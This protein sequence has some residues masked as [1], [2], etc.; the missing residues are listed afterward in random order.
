[1]VD[2]ARFLEIAKD[3]KERTADD[4]R[5]LLEMPARANLNSFLQGLK[6]EL[7]MSRSEWRLSYRVENSQCG[8]F[9]WSLSRK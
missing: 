4:V 2:R 6:M 7:V 1:M 9:H 8:Q 3:G 5:Q